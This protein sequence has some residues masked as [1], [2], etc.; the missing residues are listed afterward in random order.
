ML[1]LPQLAASMSALSPRGLVAFTATP[2]SSS[3]AARWSWPM[4]DVYIRGVQ[5]PRFLRSRFT[6]RLNRVM[7]T[8]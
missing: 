6:S 3:R 4:Y 8:G 1:S 2:A 7:E 5:P